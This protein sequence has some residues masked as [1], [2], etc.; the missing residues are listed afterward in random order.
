MNYKGQ[1]V[2]YMAAALIPLFLA[3]FF[4]QIVTGVFCWKLAKRKGYKGYFFT[5][6][7][8]GLIG[9]IY[10]VGLPNL[11]AEKNFKLA[12]KQMIGLHDRLEMLEAGER[13]ADR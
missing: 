13:D 6:L 1:Q 7:F 2:F 4:T 9:L 11:K 12:M 3:L 5:G 8:F 10:V